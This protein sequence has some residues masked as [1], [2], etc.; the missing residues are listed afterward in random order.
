[1]ALTFFYALTI[2]FSGAMMPGPLLTYTIRQ[3][4]TYG[5]RAGF[6]ITAGHSLLEIILLILIFMGFNT[7]LQ[8]PAAQIGIGI[9]GGALLCW[10]GFSMIYSAYKNKLTID[11]AGSIKSHGNMLLSGA[12]I[13][14]S[15]PYFL[16]W[17]AVIGLSILMQAYNTFGFAGVA[18]FFAG[19]FLADMSWYGLVSII[20]GSTR[21]FIKQKPYRIIIA[22]LGCLLIFFGAQF[23]IKAIIEMV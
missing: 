11:T 16:L 3:S 7:V 21:R 17:W 1:M 18:V 12:V 6:I 5:S 4:L 15:N 13:S 22:V 14:A 9:A 19:H 2:G 20:V 23:A 8:S 10:M